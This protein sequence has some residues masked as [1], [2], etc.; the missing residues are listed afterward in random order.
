MSTAKTV[1][2]IGPIYHAYDG[3]LVN[4]Q[5]CSNEHIFRA[6]RIVLDSELRNPDGEE[7]PIHLPISSIG[8][9]DINLLSNGFIDPG[10]QNK[11]IVNRIWASRDVL[12]EKVDDFISHPPSNEYG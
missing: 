9:L 4:F 2:V 7:H 8:W 1:D 6:S 11:S 12:I 3:Y 5:G 10:L